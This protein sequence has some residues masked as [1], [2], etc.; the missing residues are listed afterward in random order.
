M[1]VFKNLTTKILLGMLLLFFAACSSDVPTQTQTQNEV[2][3]GLVGYWIGTNFVFTSQADSTIQ[4]NLG[5]FGV[6]FSVT[7]NPDSSY[8]ST[9]QFLGQTTVENGVISIQQNTLTFTQQSD[10]N[11][12]GT[13]SLNENSMSIRFEEEAFD[14]DQDGTDEP[15]ILDINLEKSV[16]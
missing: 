12:S 8:S 9:T 16:Q 6:V 10:V 3:D 15:A 2:P 11:R 1:S 5:Q 4:V 13:F 14:F 7:V